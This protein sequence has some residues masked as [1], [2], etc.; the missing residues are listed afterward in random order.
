[1]IIDRMISDDRTL[2]ALMEHQQ[3]WYNHVTT[4]VGSKSQQHSSR[5]ASPPMTGEK[6]SH[7]S[8]AG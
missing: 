3:R 6:K 4:T 1:M 5:S 8:M 7:V 2:V